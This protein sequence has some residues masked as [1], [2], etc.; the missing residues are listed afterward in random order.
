MIYVIDSISY[1][2]SLLVS[3]C[4]CCLGYGPKCIILEYR[5]IAQRSKLNGPITYC[6][7]MI[8]LCSGQGDDERHLSHNDHLVDSLVKLN[9]PSDPLLITS[10]VKVAEQIRY[11]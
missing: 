7:V 11:R 6:L 4:F 3:S 10:R 8:H 5:S 1:V 9:D 2:C